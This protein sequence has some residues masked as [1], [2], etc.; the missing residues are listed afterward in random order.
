MDTHEHKLPAR[1][2]HHDNRKEKLAEDIAYTVNHAVSCT[3][4]DL[5]GGS[6]VG[7]YLSQ[8]VFKNWTPWCTHGLGV[9]TAGEIAGD[10]AG[11]LPTIAVQR[12]APWV[13]DGLQTVLE[14]P[15]GWAFKLG[16]DR[17]ARKWALEHGIDLQSEQV[18]NYAE[19]LYKH[20]VEHLP[21][22]ALW[23]GIALPISAEF[24]N[25]MG[26][27]PPEDCNHA[28]HNHHHHE[29]H[30]HGHGA[31]HWTR[32]KGTLAHG[33]NGKLFSTAILLTARAIAPE[34]ARRW[35]RWA[36][37]TVY[38]PVTKSVSSLFGVD[39]ETVQR[40]REKHDAMFEAPT[41]EIIAPTSAEK[42]LV[43]QSRAVAA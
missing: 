33:I 17:S 7:M 31:S 9:W 4:V 36:S 24:V 32:F 38:Y 6:P 20:E 3:T 11:V 25:L 42:M 23:T 41:P 14:L 21:H 39:E 15:L 5:L 34:S 1:S 37:D 27:H 26:G 43:E 10:V 12:Y 18:R 30:H 22:A 13:L 19:G 8:R 28:H 2:V 16:A 29:H 35:D 40:V